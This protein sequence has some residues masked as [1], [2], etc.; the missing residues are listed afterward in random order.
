MIRIGHGYDV[1]AFG[2]SKPLV[3]GGVSISK[4]IGLLAHS[5]GD[6]VIHSICDALL[7]AS[8]LG[9][10]GHHF[11]D[12]SAEFEGAD[13]RG[14]LRKVFELIVDQKL[15]INNLDITII[16]QT[17][18]M[19]AHIKE[20][21]MNISSDLNLQINQVNLKATTT[22][23]LGY[24]GRKEGIAVHCVCLLEQQKIA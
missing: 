23:N 12:T 13:S 18:K 24:I 22:E 7:G 19:A 4:H 15:S 6:V 14:L 21:Q 10:I 5:D 3:L 16:A 1:H 9:D 11:P 17:P 20:M 2:G 8:A